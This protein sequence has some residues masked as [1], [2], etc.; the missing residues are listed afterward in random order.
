MQIYRPVHI[1]KLTQMV[2]KVVGARAQSCLVD[3]A[4]ALIWRVM[5]A[6]AGLSAALG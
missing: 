3:F 4:S 2:A 5:R 6:R 1:R